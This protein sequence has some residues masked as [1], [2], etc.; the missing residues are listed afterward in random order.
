MPPPKKNEQSKETEVDLSVISSLF[1]EKKIAK[2]SGTLSRVI[3]QGE[4]QENPG[5]V[6]VV[7]GD[8]DD[9]TTDP[10]AIVIEK[11]GDQIK[12]IIVKCP[13]GRHAEL[14]CEYE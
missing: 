13:C 1:L 9:V 4:I 7:G 10:P 8:S 14:V 2:V 6:Q 3:R 5:K 11:D 12:K